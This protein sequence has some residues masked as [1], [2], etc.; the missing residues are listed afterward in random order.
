[1]SGRSRRRPARKP[2]EAPSIPVANTTN[3]KHVVGASSF[4]L[5]ILGI[6]VAAF[7][8]RLLHV[9]QTG[10]VPS[11]V[12]LMGD[13]KGYFDWASR[14]A[15]GAWYGEE[16]FYQAPLYPYFLAVVIS[17]FGESV[18][19]IRICQCVL[20]ATAV[21]L[22]GWATE[23][24]FGRAAGLVAAIGFALLPA[25]VYYDGLV[26][27]ASL[28]S[29]LLC[30]FLFAIARWGVAVPLG[31][32]DA[33]PRYPALLNVFGAG[34]SLALLVL[35]RENTLLWTPL[36]MIWLWLHQRRSTGEGSTNELTARKRGLASCAYV[37]GLAVIL[38]PVAARNA[39]LGGEWSPTTFQAGPNF[40]IGNNQNANGLY[41]PL[42]PGHETP[43][44]ER[45]DAVRLAERESGRELTSREVS[46]F[47]FRKAGEE[48]GADPG[49]WLQLLAIKCVM[50]V[51]YFE[52]PDVESLTV[53]RDASIVLLMFDRVWHFGTLSVLAAIGFMLTRSQWRA[54]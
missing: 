1:M 5:A 28:A 31:E 12:Y 54:H 48:I 30:L 16:T 34:V 20:G 19:A 37:A 33:Q 25:A 52:V 29:F 39:S 8:L 15:G 50:V 53:Y 32:S 36:P 46:Q 17:V 3:E 40:Y 47:W 21:G 42:V 7:F 41:L 35:V 2:E 38:F 18:V 9:F 24:R 43:L 27:K 14:I 11:A 51:N 49:R 4:G 22:L 6:S 23:R 13:A 45:S 10:A 44:H 26:Q